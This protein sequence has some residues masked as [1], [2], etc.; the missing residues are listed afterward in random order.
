MAGGDLA[1]EQRVA[2]L[3]AH[4][5]G[6]AGCQSLLEGLRR[7]LGTYAAVASVEEPA[8]G[9]ARAVLAELIQSEAAVAPP[10]RARRQALPWT[11]GWMAAVSWSAAA[12]IL[13]VVVAGALALDR[14]ALQ[15]PEARP[16]A[17]AARMRPVQ[18]RRASG[19]GVEL[20]WLLDGRNEPY[21]VL[22]SASP[23][24]FSDAEQV[25]V[26]GSR[27]VAT[28]DLPARRLGDRKVTYFRV[29]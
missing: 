10:R 2:E 20:S 1:S 8:E 3:A 6:C 14:F 11:P 5:E 29:Q 28:K 16:V 19:T 9:L 24:D 25:D 27:L 22:A 13:V 26:A 4:V 12:G 17:E 18:V 21:H 15:Q 23:R 7:D